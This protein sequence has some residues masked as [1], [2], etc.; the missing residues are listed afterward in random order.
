MKKRLCVRVVPGAPGTTPAAVF[1]AASAA[2]RLVYYLPKD[3]ELWFAAVHVGLPVAAAACFLA[4][5]FLGQRFEKPGLLAALTLGVTFFILK[6][7]T[8][9]PLHRWLCTALYLGVLTLFG[10]TILGLLPTKKLLYPLFGLPLLVH[11]FLEDPPKYLFAHVPVW[12]WLPEISVLC[13]MAGLLTLSIALEAT[14][15]EETRGFT[16]VDG[17]PAE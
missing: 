15:P 14:K 9:A 8:F 4:A 2:L 7:T 17:Q 12:D 10:G 16:T 11:L 1:M 13:I 3:L 5:V 6:A